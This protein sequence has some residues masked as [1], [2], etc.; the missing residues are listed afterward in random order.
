MS[1]FTIMS[2]KPSMSHS[3]EWIVNSIFFLGGVGGI[4][5]EGGTIEGTTGATGTT[6]GTTGT[7]GT[8]WL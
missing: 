1:E 6:S 2:V 7:S 5:G 3:K 8:V 4:G